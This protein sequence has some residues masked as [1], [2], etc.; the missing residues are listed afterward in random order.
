MLLA[1]MGVLP[2]RLAAGG[3]LAG[4]PPDCGTPLPPAESRLLRLEDTAVPPGLTTNAAAMPASATL[5]R[6]TAHHQ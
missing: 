2:V 5:P 4:A 6:I 3:E 1:R